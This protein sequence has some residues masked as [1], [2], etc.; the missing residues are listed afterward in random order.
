MFRGSITILLC[1]CCLWAFPQGRQIMLDNSKSN[2]QDGFRIEYSND[3]ELRMSARVKAIDIVDVKNEAGDFCELQIDG[4]YDTGAKGE[5]QLP[6]LRKLVQIPHGASIKAKI[7]C[8]DTS[9]FNLSDLNI[10]SKLTPRQPSQAKSDS[11]H[12]F[13]HKR[14]A[15][16]HNYFTRQDLATVTKVGTMRGIDL[17]QIAVNPVRYNP[18]K[19]SLMVL[20]GIDIDFEIE[21]DATK[22]GSGNASPFF[23]STYS[24]IANYKGTASDL[25][26]Y[27]VKYLIITDT[28]YV[29]ALKD[30]IEWKRLK[31]FDVIVATTD[32]I[33]N[34]SAQIKAWI[35][36]QYKSAT[37]DS[38]APSFLLLAADTDKIPT[39]KT[40]NK[41]GYGTD[42]YY[43]CMDGADDIIPDLYYG[44]FSARTVEDMKSIVDKTITY[45][46]YL[47]E[48]PTY[49]SK[50][51]LISGYDASYRPSVGI[52]TLNYI[53][54]NRI[55][56]ANGYKQVNK[57]TTNYT[58]C[59][60]DTSVSVG[61]MTYTAHGTTTTWVEPE[62]TQTKVNQ[63][64]NYGKFP[65]VIANCCLSGNI[66]TKEC[67]GET[68]LRKANSGAVAYIGSIPKTY[69]KEDFYWAVGAHKYK[70]GVSPKVE[71]TTIGAFDA[72]FVSNF[73][74]GD[75]M[76]YAGNLAVTEAHD[77]SYPSDISTQYYWEAYNF[78]GDPSLL[79]Y[80]GEGS[81]NTVI[82][83][84]HIPL[85]QT[86]II[87]T[88]EV[89][90][91]V[92]ITRN[93]TLIGAGIIKDN[94]SKKAEIKFTRL[95][96]PGDYSIVVT[97]SRCKPYIG[98]ITAIVPDQPYII[99]SN[100]LS[101]CDITTGN[102]IDMGIA[103]R[104][105]GSRPSSA[106]MFSI[107]SNNE[108]VKSIS[109]SGTEIKNLNA[110]EIDTLKNAYR[111]V[112]A[113]NIPNK[114][115]IPIDITI[116]G[117]GQRFEQT[118]SLTILAPNI[119][120]SPNLTIEKSSNRIMPGD[121]V[122]VGITVENTG[123]AILDNAKIDL[124]ADQS[125][126]TLKKESIDIP[127][128]APKSSTVCKFTMI[129]NGA[130]DSETDF[131][132]DAI[133]S[134]PNI[135]SPDTTEYPMTVH[136]LYEQI[137]GKEH[138]TDIYYPFNNHYY[139]GIGQILYTADDLGNSPK[140]IDEMAFDI[141]YTAS[142]KDFDGF[143]NLVIKIKYT[144]NK[145]SEFFGKKEYYNMNDAQTVLNEKLSK[146]NEKGLK[147][148][149]FDS[150]FIYDGESNIIVEITWGGNSDYVSQDERTRVYAHSTSFNS[151]GYDVEDD[152][153]D[154]YLYKVSNQ[155][156]NTI[157]RFK[158]NKN[159]VFNIKDTNGNPIPNCTINIG[160]S[161]IITDD[162]G[163]IYYSTYSTAIDFPYEISAY[164]YATQ[165][166]TISNKK[167]SSYIDLNLNICK[168]YSASFHIMHSPS[169]IDA[170]NACII[171]M[172]KEYHAD[173]L[174]IVS[175][176]DF[177]EGKTPIEISK[178]GHFTICD[179]VN[180]SSDTSLTYCLKEYPNIKIKVVSGQDAIAGANVIFD[181]DT[182]A[183]DND[184]YATIVNVAPKTHKIT[185]NNIGFISFT[186][187]IGSQ[188]DD[189]DT[190]LMLKRLP[191][192]KFAVN[193]DNSPMANATIKID[194]STNTTDSLGFTTFAYVNND[195]ILRYTINHKDILPLTDSIFIAQNDTTLT[196][197]LT[198]PNCSIQFAIS[199][200]TI[201]Q[202]GINVNV[203]GLAK[204][205]DTMGLSKFDNIKASDTIRYSIAVSN[206]FTLTNYVLYSPYPITI[207]IDLH[208]IDTINNSKID[209]IIPVKP[210]KHSI[211][212]AVSDKT[213][214]ISGACISLNDSVILT[215]NN[216]I[217]SYNATNGELLNYTVWKDGYTSVD[218][219]EKQSL[220]VICNKD[221]IID[222]L[223]L[224]ADTTGISSTTAVES[225]YP[226][227]SNG[228][229][230]I[231][232]DFV[233]CNITIYDMRGSAV[234]SILATSNI[235]DLQP[236]K[237]G[238][239]LMLTTTP[240]GPVSNL[241][242]IK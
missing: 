27:P 173:N 19:N 225:I 25:T 163:V 26:K 145:P 235:I 170:A 18:R 73:V 241:I 7:V 239:Y 53:A 180:I 120:L 134:C 203:L 167:D 160:D 204:A 214:P 174:G 96:E 110:F 222:I 90:S 207:S 70:S 69:W 13:V 162:N 54:N 24:N 35:D 61:L 77:N 43:A 133:A 88:A 129:A 179:T 164:G 140:R 80:F 71:E 85:N 81:E 240:N 128:L 184:G 117:G 45:E 65:F 150:P 104:N 154:L 242:V 1:L 82:H 232:N 36:N 107:S 17:Y 227:P 210:T 115:V 141:S 196:L 186:G 23:E 122:I 234:K 112:L 21:P 177:P 228:T 226:N 76:L 123:N 218:G 55:N 78:L 64:G 4:S 63:F 121:T 33:G 58:G 193:L 219:L 41:T 111:I 213:Q 89:G 212:F 238:T 189:I 130:I 127:T 217:A 216:G 126:V 114:T 124:S 97:K 62:L 119:H 136:S 181:N 74:C 106:S 166:G 56:S 178:Q 125:I 195:T 20:N 30:F 215:N 14:R 229:I 192:V 72:P 79:V 159:F 9:Y 60:S 39:S 108:Y 171:I 233:G 113:N 161:T 208:Q 168:T 101:S 151:V 31:G 87:V 44:R 59:Y 182:L 2:S 176:P 142:G 42:L 91:Y 153:D 175:I 197:N 131:S 143:A 169:N 144:N 236:I 156:P 137:I 199:D 75:A 237:P 12:K 148:F 138:S 202:K 105:A 149:K 200:S 187:N 231:P 183:T 103:F 132:L 10:K 11:V 57:F 224:P 51:T 84:S 185:I 109:T 29:S 211:L 22:A 118:L 5:P 191:Q 201:P 66:N 99:A 94:I 37:D 48:D 68:W 100:L 158:E 40:G 98:K 194:E 102:T 139:Y 165:N 205:T 172:N 198:R 146:I 147:T 46:K 86:S 28:A 16:R 34:T 93:D 188:N 95:L 209:T 3:R 220:S 15:Y 221:I 152:K 52:P 8:S 157:F 155:R 49:L 206:K 83:D 67:I 135:C 223:L 47:F 50:S 38:P 190:T 32:T 230:N 92:A 6:A 116:E